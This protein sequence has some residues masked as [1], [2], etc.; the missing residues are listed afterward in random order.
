MAIDRGCYDAATDKKSLCA[1]KNFSFG[2]I[3]H[4]GNS[5]VLS[6]QVS[7]IG[8]IRT[9]KNASRMT[10]GLP[11]SSRRLRFLSQ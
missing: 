10:K 6:E 5:F 1:D 2:N 8:A 3:L 7:R 9:H 11:S 4:N